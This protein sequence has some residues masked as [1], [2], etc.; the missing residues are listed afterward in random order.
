MAINK[1]YSTIDI[2]KFIMALFVIM[3]HVKPNEHSGLLTMLF[4][5]ALS[6][7]VPVFFV[8]SSLFFFNKSTIGNTSLFKYCKR[9]G[10]LYFCWFI[11]DAW[12]IWKNKSYFTQSVGSGYM[13][14]LK[15]LIFASTF[16]GSWYLSASVMGVTLVFLLNKF[17]HPIIV[18]T[19]TFIV[20]CYIAKIEMLPESMR[21]P[22]ELYATTF[23]KEVNLSFP[24]QMVWISI[25]QLLSIYMPKRENRKI[26][27]PYLWLSFIISYIIL[28]FYNNSLGLRIIMVISI[29]CI[30]ILI[31]IKTHLIY[32]R[33]RNYSVLMFFFHFSIAGKMHYFTELVGDT[34]FTNWVYYLIVVSLSIFFAE[35]ILR[36]E[37][38]KHLSFLK[39]I[40]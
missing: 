24:A 3:I 29:I 37:K 30:C 39:Y 18:F 13:E 33:I 12:F 35:I 23:R 11:I 9:I 2:L 26:W 15:D 40:H 27:I 38:N 6:V 32:E 36:L 8:I 7:A 28:I 4:A 31:E 22:Y 34:L 14:F 19:I 10:L 1:Q 20:A 17:L 25:G 16:P 21:I 5:P